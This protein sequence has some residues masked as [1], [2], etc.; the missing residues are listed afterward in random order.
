MNKIFRYIFC[1]LAIIFFLSSCKK[2]AEQYIIA[3]S[4]SFNANALTASVS[5]VVLSADNQN[6]TVVTFAWSAANFG[7]QPAI[8]YTLQIDVPTDTATWAKAQ[9]FLI[10]GDSLQL[11]I[12]GLNMN[13]LM[14]QFGLKTGISDVIAIRVRADVDQ[15]SG[16]PSSIASVFSNVILLNVTPYAENLFITG[17]FQYPN[18]NTSAAIPLNPLP[19]YPGLYEAYVYF[20]S[21][22]TQYF[23]YTTAQ[24]FNHTNYGDGGNGLMTTNGNAGAMSIPDSGYYELWANLAKNT[25]TATKTTW[26]VIGDAT[27]YGWPQTNGPATDVPMAYDTTKQVWSVTLPLTQ[28]GS[29][30]FR[31][32]DQWIIDFGVDAEG[33]LQYADNPLLPYIDNGNPT[34]SADGIYTVTL[35]L[36]ISGQH[37]YTA[38]KN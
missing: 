17:T 20:S 34:V 28:T 13:S 36:H 14:N 1:L 16:A 21:P 9:T 33:N 23:K 29:F 11:D 6:D 19:G 10:S 7:K 3:S 4:G 25:W 12:N 32:N 5:S 2:D 15:N 22:G 30:K 31:A 24:D 27:P 18:W 37:T 38:V 26:A 35:D 8:T